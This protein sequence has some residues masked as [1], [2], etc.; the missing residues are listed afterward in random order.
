MSQQQMA[1]DY[2]AARPV[3]NLVDLIDRILDK[4][5]VIDLYVKISV[6]GLELLEIQARIV[7]AGVD[8]Y[9][10]Y[11]ERVQRLGL[12][13]K[14]QIP[15]N[16]NGQGGLGN[17]LTGSV[18]PTISN[19]AKEASSAAKPLTKPLRPMSTVQ[20]NLKQPMKVAQRP[21]QAVQRN[22]QRP[23]G[24]ARTNHPQDG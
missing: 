18:G 7:I 16:N 20:R 17:G 24:L 21:L 6:V 3:A 9:L 22:V 12:A 5:L 4:G 1:Y 10:K 11:A 8:T 13:A 2:P 14:P 23:G 19:V 15:P